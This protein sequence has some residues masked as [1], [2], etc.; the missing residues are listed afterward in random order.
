VHSLC[1]GASF[2]IIIIVSTSR[3]IPTLRRFSESF[4]QKPLSFV[5]RRTS[6]TD[7]NF[8]QV[9]RAQPT[10][11]YKHVRTRTTGSREEIPRC[12]GM[13]QLPSQ[14]VTL[15]WGPSMQ[16]LH[17]RQLE[18][19]T[20]IAYFSE[21][22]LTS[23]EC[24]YAAGN[25]MNSSE[26]ISTLEEKVSQLEKLLYASDVHDGN[27]SQHDD[28]PDYMQDSCL[29]DDGAMESVVS[30]G[31]NGPEPRS[32]RASFGGFNILD[33]LHKLCEDLALRKGKSNRDF[34]NEDKF[35]SGFD[36]APPEIK[37]SISWDIYSS[38]PSRGKIAQ[39]IHDV[40]T[41]SCSTI[42]FL[43]NTTLRRVT[44]EVLEAAETG[45]EEPSHQS[46]CLVFAVLAL[47]R[48]CEASSPA[49]T[50]AK[51]DGMAHRCVCINRSEGKTMLTASKSPIF[52][53]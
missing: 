14:E 29:A 25:R 38:L 8:D 6:R 20:S 49:V 4:L 27:A 24:Q 51:N 48:L 31:N 26:Y 5:T 45:E 52:P 36:L 33:R 13:Q 22:L 18:Y 40:T 32:F 47:A 50:I 2:P 53:C 28:F 43:D 12:P 41:T 17:R 15:R 44:D 46:M 30:V 37:P 10:D 42:Q 7:F 3:R 19:E 11:S 39:A 1:S 9:Q 16:N 23:A 21:L 35:S 34:T